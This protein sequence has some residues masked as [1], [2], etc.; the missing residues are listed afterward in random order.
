MACGACKTRKA[1][2][3][4]R[5]KLLAPEHAVQ[6][7][8]HSF[9]SPVTGTNHSC[10]PATSAPLAAACTQQRKQFPPSPLPLTHDSEHRA[11]L[12]WQMGKVHAVYSDIFSGAQ[13]PLFTAGAGAD[14]LIHGL[15]WPHPILHSNLSNQAVNSPGISHP[16]TEVKLFLPAPQI[17][18]GP[19]KDTPLLLNDTP[20]LHDTGVW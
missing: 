5:R 7:Q 13:D 19:V 12:S 20:S 4:K 1:G 15:L 17:I 16:Q 8:G 6:S 18:T 3:L 9:P 11:A 10:L 2:N 14:R